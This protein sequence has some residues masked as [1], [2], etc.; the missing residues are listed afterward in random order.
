MERIDWVWLAVVVG[1]AVALRAA[2]IAYLNV[3]PTDGRFDDSVFYFNTGRLIA[4]EGSYLDPYGRGLTAQWTPGYPLALAAGFKVFGVHLVVAKVLNVLFAA[5]TVAATYGIGRAMFDRRVAVL[6]AVLLAVLPGHIYFQTLVYAETMFLMVV[7]LALLAVAVW[8]VRDRTPRW[9][10]GLAIGFLIG[11]ATMV[12]SEGILLA[13]AVPLVWLVTVRPW[14]RAGVVGAFA[15]AGIVIALMPWTARNWIQFGQFIP[16]RT[17]A[18]TAIARTLD[19]EFE[20]PRESE[21]TSLG[22]AVRSFVDEPLHIVADL[23]DNVRE[24]YENDGDAVR[25]AQRYAWA[26]RSAEYEPPLSESEDAFWRGIADRAFFGLGAAALLGV[27]VGA[28]RRERGM[29]MLVAMG[30][31]W[32]V[33]FAVVLPLTRYHVPLYPL[34]A[35]G[36]GIFFVSAWDVV[37]VGAG[38]A[39]AALGNGRVVLPAR[40]ARARD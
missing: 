1:L 21:T 38:R 28:V 11:A 20:N 39:L 13:G 8:T 29:A 16:L 17:D 30:L 24:L 9:W 23:P 5:V 37:R 26:R 10:Q 18:D 32:T 33:F 34:L 14:R 31:V 25:L 27:V 7:M 15:A 19:P 4:E 6:G 22:E 12:R 36:A 40:P 2:W 3:D 35:V